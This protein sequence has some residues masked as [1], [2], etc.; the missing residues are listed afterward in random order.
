MLSPKTSLA[1]PP[2]SFSLLHC[3]HVA[4]LISLS[5]AQLH[6]RSL[7]D[8]LFFQHPLLTQACTRGSFA[9]PPLSFLPTA[10]DCSSNFLFSLAPHRLSMFLLPLVIVFYSMHS[11]CSLSCWSILLPSSLFPYPTCT[12]SLSQS[13]PCCHFFTRQL[14]SGQ[15]PAPLLLQDTCTS[16]KMF[17]RHYKVA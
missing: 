7:P 4:I 10:M 11:L 3:T 8:T 15:T 5:Q 12:T 16:W 17:S 14:P 1:S 6:A 9:I 13:Q 2:T